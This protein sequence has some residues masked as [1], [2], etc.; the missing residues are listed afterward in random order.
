MLTTLWQRLL[1]ILYSVVMYALV[2]VMLYHLVWRGLRDRNYFRR[3]SERF[4]WYSGPGLRESLWVHAVS[5]GEVNAAATL[6]DALR[7]A[8]P[9]NP[10]VVTTTTPT[11]AARVQALWGGRVRHLYLPYDLPGAVRRFLRHA[12]P[13][14][15][16]IL[17]TEIWPNLYLGSHARGIPLMLVNARLSQRSGRGYRPVL[18]L[19]RLA[20]G[21]VDLIAA[22][23]D[24][25]ARRLR[26]VG[27]RE[28]RIRIV[29]NL[30]YDLRLPDGLDTQARRWRAG[31]DSAR[32]VW[33]AASTHE[34][35]ERLVLD[36]H[37]ALRK[38]FPDLLLLWAPRHPERFGAVTEQA[39]HRGFRVRTRSACE[40]PAI[41]TDCFVLDSM[42]E[43]LAFYAAAD[44]AFVGGSLQAIGGHNVLEPAA[45]GVPSVVGPHTFNFVEATTLMRDE[46]ALLQVED[47][48]GLESALA[49]LLDD[50][51]RRRAMG[52]AGRLTV[53]RERGALARTL[54]LIA[55][56]PQ[57]RA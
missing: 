35:E 41:D 46:G 21:Q 24:A 47:V 10:V 11:G 23:T 9:G 30:K 15:A 22:Q 31:W 42:G 40:L 4:G 29:G 26:A 57:S 25:D 16:L 52:A 14:L 8:Y 53:E 1:R 5:V 18:P 45:L 7:A 55:R 33:I 6:V 48:G 54:Q 36:V 17:E 49:L 2:P 3:W 32:P 12:G 28:A 34:D 38:R 50:A 20:M 39:Q 13:R 27:A 43:L 56:L 44:A 19:I 51:P 37:A